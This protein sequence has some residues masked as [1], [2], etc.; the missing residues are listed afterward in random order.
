ML[1]NTSTHG[2]GHNIGASCSEHERSTSGTSTLCKAI[3]EFS[4]QR[5]ELNF[6]VKSKEKW[7]LP[8]FKNPRTFLAHG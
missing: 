8:K 5:S 6:Q 3:M 4:F 7:Y 1:K 2:L